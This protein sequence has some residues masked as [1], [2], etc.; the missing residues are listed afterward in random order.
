MHVHQQPYKLLC[1]HRHNFLFRYC[2][3][4]MIH[5]KPLQTSSYRLTVC[6]LKVP[7]MTVA[8]L[9]LKWLSQFWIHSHDKNTKM[10]MVCL[11]PLI[12][13]HLLLFLD[14][15]SQK[16]RRHH[17]IS[18]KQTCGVTWKPEQIFVDLASSAAVANFLKNV[19]ASLTIPSSSNSLVLVSFVPLLSSS[20]CEKP[21]DWMPHHH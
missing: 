16:R 10:N 14:K 19:N 21:L 15:E 18:I 13:S 6:P 9:K 20:H 4:L 12:D 17:V 3:I 7:L 1:G 8:A 11:T 5:C 2:T